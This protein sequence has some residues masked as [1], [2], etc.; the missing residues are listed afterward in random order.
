MSIKQGSNLIAGSGGGVS[1]IDNLTITENANEEIQT[2]G[3]IN[4]RDSSTAIKTWTGTKAQYDA[5]VTKDQNTLYNI[6]DDTDVSLTILE[7]LYPVGSVYI[8]TANTCPLSALISGSTWTQE[9]CRQLVEK[10]EP[11]DNDPSWYNLYSDGWCEQGGRVDYS[12]TQ[13]TKPSVQ[14]LKPFKDINYTI[15]LVSGNL[16]SSAYISETCYYNIQTTS[17][18]FWMFRWD[19]NNGASSTMWQACGYTSTTTSHKQFRRTA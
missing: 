3:V 11:T 2:I 5:I 18:N 19:G 15:T 10:K 7:A 6:T 12:F 17:F 14:L 13:E 9:T 8:T 4:S 1:N 16:G